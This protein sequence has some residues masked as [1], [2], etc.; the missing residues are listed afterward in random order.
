[1]ERLPILLIVIMGMAF[2]SCFSGYQI[3]RNQ[4]L[5]K[6]GEVANVHAD[7]PQGK[8]V[9]GGGF[10]IE[11]PD[12]VKIFHSMPSDGQGNLIDNGWNLMVENIGQNT[13]QA[14]VTAICGNAK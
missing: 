3:V 7:C 1:M 10:S 8:E 4:V 5:L 13:R 9:L 11:T 6:P 14:T 12:F 2:Q